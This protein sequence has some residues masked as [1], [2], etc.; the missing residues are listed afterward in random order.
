MTVPQPG[1][2]SEVAWLLGGLGGKLIPPK[3]L[4][5]NL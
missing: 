4:N 3:V 1:L 2:H 5:E